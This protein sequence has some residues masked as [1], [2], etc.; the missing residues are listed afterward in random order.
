M[1]T[2]TPEQKYKNICHNIK[3]LRQADHPYRVKVGERTADNLLASLRMEK[4]DYEKAV[5]SGRH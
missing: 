2:L 5:P 3:M 1:T 4:R